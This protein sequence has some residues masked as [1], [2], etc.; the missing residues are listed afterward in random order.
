MAK[1]PNGSLSKPRQAGNVT[2]FLDHVRII[3]NLP[4]WFRQ[5]KFWEPWF[6]GHKNADLHLRPMLYR[7]QLP[8]KRHLREWEDEIREEFIKRAPILCEA[9]P[10]TDG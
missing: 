7:G 4:R 3:R 10:A 2:E 6:R 1:L 8:S 9:L 5:E